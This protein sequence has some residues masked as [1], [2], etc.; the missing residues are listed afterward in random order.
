MDTAA[1]VQTNSLSPETEVFTSYLPLPGLG[2]V[3]INSFLLRSSQPLLVDTGTVAANASYFAA[4]SA[5]IEIDRI[6]WIW[7][8]HTDPDHTGCLDRVLVAAPQAR[9]I[10]TYLGL[11]KLSLSH[12]PIAP[13]RVLL[14][15]AGQ[16][17]DIG[18]RTLLAVSPPT[19]DA[20]ETTAV[21]DNRSRIFYSADSFGAILTKPAVS[22]NEIPARELREGLVTWTTMDS[23][24]LPHIEER[25]F[26][27]TLE[28][29]RKLDPSMIL[30]SH[31]PPATT[32]TN[33]LLDHLTAARSAPPFVGADQ[34]QFERLLT[35]A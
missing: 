28:S 9:L 4:L 26:A 6:R 5:R 21:F 12:P 22:A 34:A 15:N 10:T 32:M 3:T 29:V 31:L 27:Q 30:S 8:T 1:V 7:L 17:L 11:G 16:T 33:D 23:P 20:P 2:L 13:E 24:W 18:D 14:L 25:T 35:A 19:Y